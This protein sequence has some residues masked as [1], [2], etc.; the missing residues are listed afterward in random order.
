MRITYANDNNNYETSGALCLYIP[1]YLNLRGLTYNFCHAT[2][3]RSYFLI[4]FTIILILNGNSWGLGNPVYKINY[5]TACNRF[6]IM[7]YCVYDVCTPTDWL[8]SRQMNNLFTALCAVS[9]HLIII[10]YTRISYWST[11]KWLVY[12]TSYSSRVHNFVLK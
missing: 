10:H 1:T 11:L 4:R 7:I 12:K 3:H 6:R 5:A 2:K 8:I 9:S